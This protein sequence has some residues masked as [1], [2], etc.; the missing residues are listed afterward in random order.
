[1]SGI[2]M[3]STRRA[4][5]GSMLSSSS[6]SSSRLRFWSEESDRTSEEDEESADGTA[7]SPLGF[8]TND[9]FQSQESVWVRY[10]DKWYPGI[11]RDGPK[12][13]GLDPRM[14]APGTMGHFYLVEYRVKNNV[15]RL[16]SPLHGDLKPNTHAIRQL[17]KSVNA[18]C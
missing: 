16:F 4:T 1:M 6:S 13:K 5:N 3:H 12:L 10:E 17:V 14:Y 15:R 8:A 7:S 11:V 9:Q 2:I 18:K